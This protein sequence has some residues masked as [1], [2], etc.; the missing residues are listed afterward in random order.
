MPLR[1]IQDRDASA[2]LRHPP[3]SLPG[4][5]M[6]GLDYQANAPPLSSKRKNGGPLPPVAPRWPRPSPP[7]CAAIVGPDKPGH[8]EPGDRPS[9]RDV[10]TCPQ[11]AVAR[12]ASTAQRKSLISL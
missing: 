5:A 9:L 8:E 4:S 10:P 1:N 11:S 12:P 7:A 6:L 3:A 2:I